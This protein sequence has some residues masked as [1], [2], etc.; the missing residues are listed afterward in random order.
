MDRTAEQD[1]GGEKRV[2]LSSSLPL[3]RVRSAL[4]RHPSS[5]PK[6]PDSRPRALPLY[7]ALYPPL[8]VEG[9]VCRLESSDCENKA[10]GWEH[11][12]SPCR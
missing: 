8:S 10:M 9:K 11:G 1:L 5:G 12:A 3:S 2:D 4:V 6:Y 7:H